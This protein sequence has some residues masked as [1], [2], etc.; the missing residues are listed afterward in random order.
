MIIIRNYVGSQT[1]N[2][3]LS[4][5]MTGHI[6]TDEELKIVL[7]WSEETWRQVTE[8]MARV[9]GTLMEQEPPYLPGIR[10]ESDFDEEKE[11]ANERK[12]KAKD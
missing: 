4:S 9:G 1:D 3:F 6:I 7:G 5:V 12:H 11:A 10:F 8:T 2:L